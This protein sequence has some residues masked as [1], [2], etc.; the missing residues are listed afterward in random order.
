MQASLRALRRSAQASTRWCAARLVLSTASCTAAEAA[1]CRLREDRWRELM[2][3][4][5]WLALAGATEND[6]DKD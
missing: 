6:R 5:H 4:A 2:L 1:L 3:L